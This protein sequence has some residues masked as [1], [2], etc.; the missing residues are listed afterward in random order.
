VNLHVIVNIK[1][2]NHWSKD[3][4]NSSIYEKSLVG[5]WGS[6]AL[7]AVVIGTN[8]ALLNACVPSQH[9]SIELVK[10]CLTHNMRDIR[11]GVVIAGESAISA[12]KVTTIDD[13]SSH[14]EGSNLCNKRKRNGETVSSNL[15]CLLGMIAA[16]VLLNHH[17]L[18]RVTHHLRLLRHYIDY[19]LNLL[20][21]R[22]LSLNI[23]DFFV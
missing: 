23:I 20:E 5:A 10:R 18:R 16:L 9:D 7:E 4:R 14:E 8:I 2:T 1:E 6:D 11:E 21:E 13:N 3:A 22:H 15:D 17:R 12:S 19:L